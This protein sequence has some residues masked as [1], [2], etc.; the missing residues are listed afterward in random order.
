MS[1]DAFYG[2]TDEEATDPTRFAF[3]AGP[4]HA[5]FA[6]CSNRPRRSSSRCRI[7]SP[8][9][10]TP[11]RASLS[12]AKC[13][14]RSRGSCS[15]HGRSY[16]SAKLTT[17]EQAIVDATI[18][19]HRGGRGPF[20][21]RRCFENSQDLMLCDDSMKLVL[22]RGLRVDARAPP[23]AAR[24]AVAGREGHRRHAACDEPA[25]G[26]AARATSGHRR[27]HGPHVPRRPIRR[28]VR[29]EAHPLHGPRQS[30]RRPTARVPVAQGRSCEGCG[31]HL[32]RKRAQRRA[33]STQSALRIRALGRLTEGVDDGEA[34]LGT[35]TEPHYVPAANQ[36]D[37]D[38]LGAEKGQDGE[39]LRRMIDPTECVRLS[40]RLP[41]RR[42]CPTEPP[43]AL[44]RP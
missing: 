11:W 25:R 38:A 4:R 18:A 10:P 41:S 8:P 26:E 5:T 29:R 44:P 42:G 32:P 2:R 30:A 13:P 6:P 40:P 24:V 43:P 12:P 9:T 20:E 22:R 37:A 28:L 19:K 16:R 34:E 21:Q 36:S 14:G 15:Q 7:S 1:S 27:V 23:R 3:Q 35:R 17:K 39:P 31:A 33:S